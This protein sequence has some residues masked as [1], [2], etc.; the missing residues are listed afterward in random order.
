MWTWI[1]SF[2]V[3]EENVVEENIKENV[4]VC[5]E[6]CDEVILEQTSSDKFVT[7]LIL[8]DVKAQ[9]RPVSEPIAIKDTRSEFEKELAEYTER[10]YLLRENS[11]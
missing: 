10:K 11:K 9:L 6:V 2:F 1:R 5:D 8:Q 4:E 3:K 7:S